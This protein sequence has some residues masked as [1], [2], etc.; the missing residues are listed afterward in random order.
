[1]PT[2]NELIQNWLGDGRDE[3]TGALLTIDTIHHEVHEGEMFAAE[4]SQASLANG[5]TV[6][7]MFTTGAKEAHTSW[8]VMAGGQM[9]V[10]LYEAIAGSAG[11]AVPVYNMNRTSA[12]APTAVVVHT[13]TVTNLGGT[14]ALVN[15]RI[16]PG[17]NSPSTSVG[18]GARENV[19][20]ILGTATKYLLRVVNSSGG[21]AAVN[22]FIN[23]YE[24]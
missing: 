12:G 20:W 14:V 6:Q 13:P 18:G 21:A 22:A 17:G 5:G 1:M 9:T 23:W 8:A 3:T 4:Y 11:T 10:Y 19:E 24:E 16:I 7:L 2:A 15:G